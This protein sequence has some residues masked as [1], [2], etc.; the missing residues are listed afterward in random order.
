MPYK[1]KGPYHRALRAYLE[2]VSPTIAERSAYLYRMWLEQAGKLLGFKDPKRIGLREMVRLESKLQGSETTV[3][4][5]ASVT[6]T[7]LRWCGNA[8]AGKWKISA[9]QRPKADGIFL[10][11]DQ[12]EDCRRAARS[13]GVEHELILSLAVDNGLRVI[14]MRRLTVRNAEQLLATGQSMIRSKG[15]RGGKMRLMVMSR[16]SYAPLLEYMKHRRQLTERY[17]KD[18]AL[19]L[20]REDAVRRTIVPMT[21]EV[22]LRRVTKVSEMAGVYF[23]PHDGRRTF[24]N[25]HHRSHTDIETIAALMGH[26]RIDQTFRSYIGISAQEMREA[27]DKLCPSTPIQ[28]VSTI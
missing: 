27:Q 3:A 18:P 20:I 8:D 13:L 22:V 10:E 14:D 23:R 1:H 24:G 15:R 9:K 26:E 16:A 17:R 7:F 21:Y 19:L 25:R 12:I 4:I 6:R 5:K 28:S 2:D 11:E